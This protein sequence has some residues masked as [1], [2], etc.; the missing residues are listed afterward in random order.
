MRVVFVPRSVEIKPLF[1][2]L[3]SLGACVLRDRIHREFFFAGHGVAQVAQLSLEG[4]SWACN[5]MSPISWCTI[6]RV[7]SFGFFPL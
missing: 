5:A 7:R 6:R 4:G 2:D 1:T 3:I